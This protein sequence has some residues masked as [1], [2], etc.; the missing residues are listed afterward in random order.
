MLVYR[1][2]NTYPTV[3]GRLSPVGD[4]RSAITQMAD[5]TLGYYVYRRYEA[6]GGPSSMVWSKAA[7]LC[8]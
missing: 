8:L 7:Q 2:L 1:R 5:S 6:D 3:H 4:A